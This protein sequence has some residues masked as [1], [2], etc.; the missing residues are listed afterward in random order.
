[1]TVVSINFHDTAHG[2]N[3]LATSV[4]VRFGRLA[5]CVGD[6]SDRYTILRYFV[7]MMH[8]SPFIDGGLSL[9]SPAAVGMRKRYLC[10]ELSDVVFIS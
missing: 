2:V 3:E 8:G 5:W 10:S 4:A 7:L 6:G 9:C 1:M